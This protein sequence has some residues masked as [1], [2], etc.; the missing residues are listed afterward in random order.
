MT[1]TY[2][3]Y[4]PRYTLEI[5]LTNQEA[6]LTGNIASYHLAFLN[7]VTINKN[8]ALTGLLKIYQ[9]GSSALAANFY[10]A[11]LNIGGR[12]TL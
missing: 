12:V 6:F 5:A 10:G 2:G 7:R 8:W 11:A 4:T 1:D 9:T 3:T